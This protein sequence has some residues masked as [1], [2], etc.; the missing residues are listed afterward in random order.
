MNGDYTLQVVGV[1]SS[2]KLQNKKAS[3]SLTFS[4]AASKSTNVPTPSSPDEPDSV[5]GK[6]IVFQLE[7][8]N[9]KVTIV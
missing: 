2:T 5:S 9:L 6:K 1:T 4:N 3:L 7:I 8:K